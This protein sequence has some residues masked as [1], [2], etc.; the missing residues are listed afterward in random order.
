MQFDAHGRNRR[1]V[2]NTER[3]TDLQKS[4]RI[5]I[6]GFNPVAVVERCEHDADDRWSWQTNAKQ[7]EGGQKVCPLYSRKSRQSVIAAGQFKMQRLRSD[8]IM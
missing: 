5:D 1:V 4:D 8:F 7:S 6:N 2:R 3:K